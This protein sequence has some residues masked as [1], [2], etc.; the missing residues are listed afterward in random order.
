MI[1][2]SSFI[3]WKLRTWWDLGPT[4]LRLFLLRFATELST[5]RAIQRACKIKISD[6]STNQVPQVRSPKPNFWYKS[7]IR[8][9]NTSA[10]TLSLL[11]PT[12]I[13]RNWTRPIPNKFAKFAGSVMNLK[14]NQRVCDFSWLMPHLTVLT[15]PR[16]PPS[17]PSALLLES[18]VEAEDEDDDD[19]GDGCDSFRTSQWGPFYGCCGTKIKLGSSF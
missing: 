3:S 8:N 4:M 9:Q 19:G 6:Q 13:P 17:I 5:I 11:I 14:T 10:P 1:L 12:C 15:I 7:C 2:C 18:V 16:R